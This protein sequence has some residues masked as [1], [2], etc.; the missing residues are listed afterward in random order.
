MSTRDHGTLAAFKID[1][2]KCGPC[3]ATN[4]RYVA[5][6]A[7]LIAYGQWQPYV[8]AEPV[9]QHIAQLRAAGLG[10]RRIAQ[11]SGV[12]NGSV[13]KLLYGDA[14]RGMAPSKRVRPA[15]AA[16][17]LAIR[18]DLDVLGATVLVD[19]TG[20]HRRMQALAATGWSFAR[21][22]ARLGISR[23]NLGKTMRS[24]R[25]YAATARTVRVLYDELWNQPAPEASHR[26]KIAAAR[27]R[28]LARARGWAPPLAWDDDLI[29]D[30]AAQPDLGEETSRDLALFENSEELFGQGYTTAQAAERLGVT[31]SYLNQAR[32]R[33]R[34]SREAQREAAIA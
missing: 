20:T 21:L 25:V 27:A 18:A 2:C 1:G 31:A 16:A 17:I 3:T 13:S 11:L 8:D 5:R 4:R 29:D 9:R 22:S 15:T 6:R 14:R 7:R 30:P 33:V 23:G 24:D 12:P 32:S 10:W 19:A 26:D 34:R 28:N